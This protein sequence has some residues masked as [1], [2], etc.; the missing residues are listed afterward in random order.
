[1]AII[2]KKKTE[3]EWPVVLKTPG[4]KKYEKS[5]VVL[6]FKYMTQK[7][8][9]EISAGMEYAE[10]CKSHVTGWSGVVDEDSKEIPFS[11]EAFDELLENPGFARSIFVT[12]LMVMNGEATEK[13]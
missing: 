1:M 12:Y 11:Q 3:F 8:I 13:N 5:E 10:F 4:S 9:T 2:L 6:K 7:Q